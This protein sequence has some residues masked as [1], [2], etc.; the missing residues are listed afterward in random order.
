MVYPKLVSFQ[1]LPGEVIPGTPLQGT[2]KTIPKIGSTKS[3][4]SKSPY[5]SESAPQ[6]RRGPLGIIMPSNHRPKHTLK[7]PFAI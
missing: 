3:L 1:D 7:Y 6:L 4:P 5:L 2:A